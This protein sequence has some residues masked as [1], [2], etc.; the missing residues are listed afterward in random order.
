MVVFL[1]LSILC[2][3]LQLLLLAVAAAAAAAA[4]ASC[5]CLLL[6][7]LHACC[8]CSCNL[9]ARQW[10]KGISSAS[11]SSMSTPENVPGCLFFL[12]LSFLTLAEY[13]GENAFEL[14]IDLLSAEM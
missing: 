6:Q 9:V 2:A 10:V 13:C 5:C 3:W 4:N 1:S 12:C 14:Y 11:S 8:C 7:L